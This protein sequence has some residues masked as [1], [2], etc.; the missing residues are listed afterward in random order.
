MYSS[1][2]FDLNNNEIKRLIVIGDI[3][4][5]IKR[6]KTI[7]IDANIINNNFEWIAEPP[8]TIIVQLGDQVDSL[9]RNTNENWEVLNDYEMIY[10]TEHLD[11]IARVK[12]G[13]CISLIGNHELMNIIGDFTYVS[14]LNKKEEI[15]ESL[16]K[17]QGSIALLLSKRP[18][19]LK[20]KDLLFCHAKFNIKHLEILKKY[21][22]DIFYINTIWENYLKTGKINIQDKEILDYIIIGQTGILWNRDIND[23]NETAKL[24]NELNVSYMFLGHTALPEI[25][26]LNNQIIYCDTGISR[27]FGTSKYQYID[28]NNNSINVKTINEFL[29]S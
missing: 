22:K 25:T 28:I 11:N 19:V 6:F 29:Y 26:V 27:A 9:N 17:P 2:I 18:L 20:I 14:P 16:F 4:G 5:D 13:R 8:N 21:N 3:H 7:L 12:G 24:F 1:N 15:R 23:P 10:F